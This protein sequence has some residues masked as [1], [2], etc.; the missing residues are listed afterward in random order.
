MAGYTIASGGDLR[1]HAPPST[2]RRRGTLV[3]QSLGAKKPERAESRARRDEVRRAFMT[4]IGCLLVFA[5]PIVGLFTK[6][7]ARRRSR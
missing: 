7:A 5:H 3:G 1:F 4:A 6:D 2:R